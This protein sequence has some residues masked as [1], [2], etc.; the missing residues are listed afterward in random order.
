M[1]VIVAVLVVV[2]G[3]AIFLVLRAGGVV[4]VDLRREIA[5]ER[6]IRSFCDGADGTTSH[7]HFFSFP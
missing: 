1:L 3:G 7:T 4:V 5:V 6:V 2:V